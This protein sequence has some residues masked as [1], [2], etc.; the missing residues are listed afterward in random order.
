[1]IYNI[2][3]FKKFAGVIEDGASSDVLRIGYT[4]NR[5]LKQSE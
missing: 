4:I 5:Y 3:K 2:D 1:M